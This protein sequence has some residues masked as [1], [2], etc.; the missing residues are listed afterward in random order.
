MKM[1]KWIVL[2]TLLCLS[3]CSLGSNKVNSYQG[4]FSGNWKWER[5]SDKGEFTISFSQK[6][7]TV[8]GNY[9]AI[10]QAGERIDCF[11][12]GEYSFR[13]L[14]SGSNST[15]IEF[16]F[17]TAYSNTYGKAKITLENNKL[18]WEIIEKPKGEFYA[19]LKAVLLKE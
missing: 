10:A 1:I 16:K 7:D 9:C 2:F 6:G 19:P 3:Y 12:K 18:L 14:I 17:K 4:T 15:R 13:F 8:I 5:N 11:D